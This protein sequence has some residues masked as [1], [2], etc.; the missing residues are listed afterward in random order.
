M[1]KANPG[2]SALACALSLLASTACATVL[3]DVAEALVDDSGP[4]RQA[5]PPGPLDRQ[6]PARD[7]TREP[8]QTSSTYQVG[9]TIDWTHYRFGAPYSLSNALFER[10]R[11]V[12]QACRPVF[13]GMARD[14]KFGVDRSETSLSRPIA[15]VERHER[16][17]I[18][19]R[20]RLG[21]L[22]AADANTLAA[23]YVAS[24]ARLGHQGHTCRG[25]WFA[26]VWV[27]GGEP[28]VAINR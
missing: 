8:E 10:E 13:F 14:Q 27:W 20:V 6:P 4:G 28:T 7:A 23:H 24:S 17:L 26:F 25:S 11:T 12:G 15:L 19:H 2:V 16:D 3:Q 1:I 5:P 18:D 9:P 21:T 22:R